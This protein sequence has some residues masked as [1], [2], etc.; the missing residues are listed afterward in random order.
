MYG[1]IWNQFL[2]AQST[3]APHG[4]CWRS[5]T[6]ATASGHFTPDWRPAW[7]KWHLPVRS[8]SAPTSIWRWCSGRAT[9][10]GCTRPEPWMIKT[11]WFLTSSSC[12]VLQRDFRVRDCFV[13]WSLY[14][15]L[16]LDVVF[17]LLMRKW[18]MN[19][20]TIESVSYPKIWFW[21]ELSSWSTVKANFLSSWAS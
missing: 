6:W 21:P 3:K 4:V 12:K 2:V 15:V 7:S 16:N 14:N 20:T 18:L 17:L 1:C 13:G 19:F 10:S 11:R 9:S 8:W 5:C